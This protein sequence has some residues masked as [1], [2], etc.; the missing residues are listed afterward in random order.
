MQD[1]L[2]NKVSLRFEFAQMTQ[3]QLVS[4]G[5]G[6][7]ASSDNLYTIVLVDTGIEALQVHNL[8]F[9]GDDVRCRELSTSTGWWLIYLDLTLELGQ[10]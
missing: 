1:Q 4:Y 7:R 5:L 9:Q 2:I 3:F 6:W 10:R 8:D